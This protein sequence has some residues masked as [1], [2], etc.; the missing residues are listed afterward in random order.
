M[1]DRASGIRVRVRRASLNDNFL[2]APNALIRGEGPYACLD[3]F[4]RLL[5]LGG[6]SCA[7]DV[8]MTMEDLESWVPSLGRN[9]QE[10]NRRQLREHG[11]LSMSRQQVPA[12]QTDGGQYIWT[13]EFRMDQLPVEQRDKLP[14]KGAK[15]SKRS[16]TST[17]PRN[18][19]HGDD[20]D[21]SE[22]TPGGT[23]PHSPGHRSPGHGQPGP[24]D[25]GDVYK[26]LKNQFLKEP[27]YPP[28]DEP[29]GSPPGDAETGGEDPILEDQDKLLLRG[30]R[31]RAIEVRAAM[32]R[33]WKWDHVQA[34]MQAA[35]D[36]DRSV[37]DVAVA[38][39][40]AAEDSKTAVPARI[41][42]EAWWSQAFGADTTFVASPPRPEGDRCS[43]PSHEFELKHNCSHCRGEKLATKDEPSDAERLRKQPQR[44]FRRRTGQVLA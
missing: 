22:E 14:A 2:I 23:M 35:L 3:E 30:A 24:G 43:K 20:G 5:L 28:S 29:D 42:N 12:G 40:L 39:V 19:G 16:T 9:R 1:S 37:Q 31:E 11:F 33:P 34:A 27:P 18:P 17:M 13:F 15:A 8:E 26:D 38:I 36:A 32:R 44:Q 25:R 21:G 10:A 41:L 4:G 7:D 6:L